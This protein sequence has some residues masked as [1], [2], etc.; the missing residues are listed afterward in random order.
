M[1]TLQVTNLMGCLITLLG[2][3]PDESKKNRIL[4]ILY[5][6]MQSKRYTSPSSPSPPPFPSPLPLFYYTL[7]SIHSRDLVIQNLMLRQDLLS[8][9][10]KWDP[11]QAPPLPSALQ[12]RPSFLLQTGPNIPGPNP[13][14]PSSDGPKDGPK[15]G[16]PESLPLPLPA[17]SPPQALRLRF[18]SVPPAPSPDLPLPPPPPPV[19]WISSYYLSL[20]F[21]C[22]LFSLLFCS[23]IFL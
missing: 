12:S 14:H 2:S 19:S 20:L 17:T 15:F 4:D 3:N 21:F 22:A 6:L 5:S 16:T 23:F 8:V 9:L 10:R 11:K 13:S 18:V 1:N 7:S